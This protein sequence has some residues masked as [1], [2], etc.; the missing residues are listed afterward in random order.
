MPAASAPLQLGQPFSHIKKAPAFCCCI[1]LA[2]T[3]LPKP[4][5]RTPRNTGKNPGGLIPTATLNALCMKLGKKP[6]YKPIDPYPG[7][8][9]QTSIT[10][11]E[12]QDLTSVLCNSEFPLLG[13]GKEDILPFCPNFE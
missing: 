10:M 12:L 6:M 5:M 1:G 4:T 9:H 2:E 8:R 13:N 7:M 11:S 3:T